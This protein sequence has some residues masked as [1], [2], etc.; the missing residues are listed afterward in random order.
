MEVQLHTFLLADIAGYSRFAERSGD[1]AAA[2]VAIHFA[3][4]VSRLAQDHG[5]DFVKAIGD[6]VIV[7]G[8]DAG[9]TLELALT[10]ADGGPDRPR[11]LPRVHAGMHTGPALSRAGDWW[12]TTL[13]IT[14]RV[15]AA[16][17]AGQLLVTEAARR[18]AGEPGSRRLRELGALDLKNISAPVR[19]YAPFPGAYGL[20]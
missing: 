18:A 14:A 15:A 17:R 4:Q 11:E 13:N 1:E 16:A 2:E 7:H 20:A 19:V 3:E 5:T 12:G 8:L 9:A 6:A 10:L